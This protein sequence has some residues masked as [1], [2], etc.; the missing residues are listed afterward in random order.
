MTGK[1]PRKYD[2]LLSKSI[3]MRLTPGQLELMQ[4]AADQLGE[5]FNDIW[6]H[7]IESIARAVV[8]SGANTLTTDPQRGIV[9]VK[10]GDS[11]ADE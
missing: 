6:R 7:A 10:L 3:T 11:K 2:E 1:R 9:A 4:R 5:D 8:A